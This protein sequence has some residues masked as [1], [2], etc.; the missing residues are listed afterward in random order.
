MSLNIGGT[1]DEF[2]RYKMPELVTKIEGRGN[3]IKTVITNMADV[4]LALKR[5]PAYPTKFF[6]IEL[7]ALSQWEEARNVG[8]VNGEHSKATLQKLL[9]DFIRRYVLCP[10]CKL[11]ETDLKVKAKKIE[12]R[13]KA[14]G[15]RGPSDNIHKVATYIVNHPPNK[16]KDKDKEKEKDKDSKSKKD[17]KKEKDPKDKTKSEKTRSSKAGND[18]PQNG[19]DDDHD[20]ADDSNDAE[21]NNG[22]DENGAADSKPAEAKAETKSK[23]KSKGEKEE[24]GM[25]FEITEDMTN[26]KVTDSADLADPVQEVSKLLKSLESASADEKASEILKHQQAEGFDHSE[27][28]QYVFKALVTDSMARQIKANTS[29]IQ[30]LVVSGR[31][32]QVLMLSLLEER[33]ETFSQNLKDVPAVLMTFYDTSLLEEE[34]ILTWHEKGTSQLVALADDAAGVATRKAAD[35]FIEWLKTAEEESDEE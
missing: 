34:T 14:C 17:K 1:E 8:I 18:S 24:V 32:D 10:K 12:A 7:G 28:F 5:D 2:F 19:H 22:S 27:I 35:K 3:G 23:K 20:D 29:L 21:D 26:M 31:E 9:E 6:A 13:C 11:P 33:C 15:H 4:G 25:R 16:E 30:K